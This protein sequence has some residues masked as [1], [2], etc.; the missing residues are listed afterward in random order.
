MRRLV[1]GE[2]ILSFVPD[3]EQRLW[4]TVTRRKYQLTCSRVQLQNRL[5]ALLEEMHVK[6][7]SLVSD[8]L[9][10]SARRMLEA[11]AEG[12]TDPTA[13]AALRG[14]RPGRHE[15]ATARAHSEND[16]RTENPRLPGRASVISPDVRPWF[17]ELKR[18][19][20]SR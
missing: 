15:R 7:S 20:P 12:A 1:A 10:P 3:A 4:R 14:T 6:L 13:V 17:E 11:I 5:E 18:M 16:P 8:L 2:L 19:V 9:G